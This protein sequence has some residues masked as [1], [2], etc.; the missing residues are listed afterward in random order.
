M[1]TVNRFFWQCCASGLL[2]IACSAF[3]QSISADEAASIAQD[4]SGGQVLSVQGQTNR[5]GRYVYRVRMLMP[6]GRVRDVV[7]DGQQGRPRRDE[8]PRRPRPR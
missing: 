4:R 5:Q 7:V 1:T 6:N 3:A 8:E 2:W